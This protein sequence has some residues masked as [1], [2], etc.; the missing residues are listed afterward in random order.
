MIPSALSA[1]SQKTVIIPFGLSANSQ[2]TVII[3]SAL[4]A[5][6]QKTFIIPFALSANSQKTVIIPS[7]LSPHSQKYSLS[8]SDTA[9][10][11]SAFYHPTSGAQPKTFPHWSS[12]RLRRVTPLPL[13]GIMQLK[14]SL[15]HFS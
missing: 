5:N 10:P 6:S 14:H 3:P 9:C 15:P 1:N 8:T 7:A 13:S 11:L 12:H 2:K 4:S